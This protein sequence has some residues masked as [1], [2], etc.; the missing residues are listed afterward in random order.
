MKA[1]QWLVACGATMAVWLAGTTIAG[2]GGATGTSIVVP[3]SSMGGSTITGV[4]ELMSQGNVT[5][6]VIHLEG[7]A[8]DTRHPAHIHAGTCVSANPVPSFP[9][10]TLQDGT[11][12]STVDAPLA[13]LTSGGYVIEVFPSETD[14]SQ[15]VACG[16]LTQVASA[17][18]AFPPS[19]GGGTQGPGLYQPTAVVVLV[20]LAGLV[21]FSERRSA[22]V[23]LL[24]RLQGR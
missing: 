16:A 23:L 12:V 6:V 3:L 5:A 20:V 15:A 9:L 21:T 22:L 18:T 10:M 24:N 4:A 13:T 14:L 1:R 7:E 2:A 19:G 8:P 17:Q 11:S